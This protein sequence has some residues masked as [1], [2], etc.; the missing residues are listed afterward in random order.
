MLKTLSGEMNGIYLDE[1]AEL[2]YR[3][4]FTLSPLISSDVEYR[5]ITQANARA[6]QG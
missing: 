1:G 6:I 3:G 5:Y 4:G 2:N